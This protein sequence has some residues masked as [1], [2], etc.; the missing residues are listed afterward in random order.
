MRRTL[1]VATVLLTVGATATA[2]VAASPHFKRGG[3][4]TCT[5]SGTGTNSIST[6]CRASLAG[7]GNETLVVDVEVSGFATYQCQNPSGSNEPRG[8][9]KVL[10][11]PATTPTTIDADQIKNGTVTF[12]TNPAALTAPA[13]VTG[14]QAGCNNNRWT[15]VNPNLT[16]TNIKMT[17]TQGQLLFT[18]TA[19]NP[20]G[21]TSPVTLSCS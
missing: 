14:T 8:Q 13:T 6:T 4:P 20:N 9:N 17:I 15:G 5:I 1:I 19:S 18:C 21:L 10:V 7:L 3:T 16:L 11:G 2:A 12:T